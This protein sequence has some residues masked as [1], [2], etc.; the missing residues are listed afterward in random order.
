MSLK[1]IIAFL[2]LLLFIVVCPNSKANAQ[3]FVASELK[4]TDVELWNGIEL[5][6]D[7][8]KNLAASFTYQL[9][10]NEQVQRFKSTFAQIGFSF[11]IKKIHKSFSVNPNFRVIHTFDKELVKRPLVDIGW[12]VFKSDKVQLG[13]KM[14]FQ[15]DFEHFTNDEFDLDFYWRNRLT[16]SFKKISQHKKLNNI[17]PYLGVILFTRAYYKGT[18]ADQIRFLAGINYKAKKRQNVRLGYVYRERFNVSRPSISH[19]IIF[20]MDFK[21][22]DFKK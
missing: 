20:K 12:R 22:R 19:I 10:F 6:K 8:T 4:G 14:R 16:L 9:R 7:I 1:N 5:S 15:K 18:H 13:Y 11:P 21:V 2:V 3:L 17:E